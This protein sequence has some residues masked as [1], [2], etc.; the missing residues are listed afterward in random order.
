MNKK[1]IFFVIA[2]SL[3]PAVVF[4]QKTTQGKKQTP[5]EPL[6]TVD[7]DEDIYRGV[8]F[9]ADKKTYEGVKLG[10]HKTVVKKNVYDTSLIRAIKIGD[11]DRVRTLLFARIDVNEKNYAGIT[12][13]A[14]AAEKGNMEII[15]MLVENGKAKVNEKSSYGVTPLIAASAMGRGEVIKYLVDHEADVTARDDKGKTALLYAVRFNQPQAVESLIKYNN[16]TVNLPDNDGNSP[17][18]YAAQRGLLENVK[19]LIK[20]GADP[21]YRN[22][23]TG[24]SPLLAASAGGYP[25]VA[26]TLVKNGGADIHLPDRSGRTA[27]FYAVNNNRPETLRALIALKS[28]I[29]A[30]DLAGTTPLMVASAKNNLDC[31]NVLLRQKKSL[32]LDMTDLQG[33][34]ALIYSAYAEGTDTAAKLLNAGLNINSADALGNTPLLTAI[35][36]KNERLALFFLQQGADLTIANRAKEN[37]F[38]LTRK[39]LPRTTFASVLDVKRADTEQQLL[40]VQAQRLAEVRSLEAELEQEEATAKRLAQEQAEQ[41]AAAEDKLADSEQE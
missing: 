10:E 30:Q 20:Y 28:N 24:I 8:V 31:L 15:R 35:K 1:I 26:R 38:T 23:V 19:I 29:N 40:Q 13:L 5:K 3:L 9:G 18:I 4:A 36:A 33:R 17:L 16:T 2:C 11:P 25:K 41:Q 27:V 39:Y 32:K 34:N 22:P 6:V 14:V 12:P 21:D 37:A 7:P